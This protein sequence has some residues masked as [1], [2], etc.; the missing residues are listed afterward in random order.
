MTSV[1]DVLG[2]VVFAAN[3]NEILRSTADIQLVIVE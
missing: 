3:D 2:I 1:F